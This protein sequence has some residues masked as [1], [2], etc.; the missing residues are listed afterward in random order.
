MGRPERPAPRTPLRT[1]DSSGALSQGLIARGAKAHGKDGDRPFV[2]SRAFFA[3]SQR[4]GAIWTGDNAAT[5]EHMQISV[6]MLLSISLAGMP[7]CGALLA[8]TPHRSEPGAGLLS[9]G[10]AAQGQGVRQAE[11]LVQL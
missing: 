3:G 4:H 10:C 6:P 9:G 11:A 2:L 7:F 5:W 8:C 1:S